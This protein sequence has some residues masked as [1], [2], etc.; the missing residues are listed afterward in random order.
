MGKV[1]LAPHPQ[2]VFCPQV[3]YMYQNAIGP[4]TYTPGFNLL[5]QPM[6]V[7]YPGLPVVS[8]HRHDKHLAHHKNMP[9]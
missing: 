9:I 2:G 6:A 4:S 7:E 1:V 5:E 3:P 8:V